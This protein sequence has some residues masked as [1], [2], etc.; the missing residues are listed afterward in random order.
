MEVSFLVHFTRLPGASFFQQIERV[1]W[2]VCSF[3]TVLGPIGQLILF[4]LC[5]LAESSKIDIIGYLSMS[6][7][8]ILG[9][10]YVLARVFL[11]VESIR[12]LYFLPPDAFTATWAANFPHIA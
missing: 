2:K 5:A 8:V 12:S 4:F 7:M 3:I 11:L 9:G 10:A 6:I 1:L